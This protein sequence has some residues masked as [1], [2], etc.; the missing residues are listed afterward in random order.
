MQPPMES[1]PPRPRSRWRWLGVPVGALAGVAIALRTDAVSRFG[2]RLLEVLLE[3]ATGEDATIAGVNVAY[4][5]LEVS[6][7]GA[8]LTHPGTGETVVSA[9]TVTATIGLGGLRRVTLDRPRVELH[10][11]ADG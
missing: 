11:D 8:V 7:V 10:L 1:P 2:A 5:P 4:F 6:V 3:Q 9:S